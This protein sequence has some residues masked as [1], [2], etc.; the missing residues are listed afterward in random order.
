MFRKELLELTA[1][2]CLGLWELSSF[3][4]SIWTFEKPKNEHRHWNMSTAWWSHNEGKV[5]SIALC[6]YI[7][8]YWFP[9][10]GDV[11][12]EKSPLSVVQAAHSAYPDAAPRYVIVIR[13]P[14]REA[15]NLR[16]LWNLLLRNRF[17][18]KTFYPERHPNITW[19][20]YWQR[21]LVKLM[22]V[23]ADNSDS[24]QW[25]CHYRDYFQHTVRNPLSGKSGTKGFFSELGTFLIL[26]PSANRKL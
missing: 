5:V 17:C 23:A 2:A 1:T 22:V 20:Y 13:H 21:S 10:F 3:E 14:L 25:D 15:L 11:E 16:V 7:S 4:G 12:T 18:F 24:S 9:C 19:Q 26:S 6:M 8:S